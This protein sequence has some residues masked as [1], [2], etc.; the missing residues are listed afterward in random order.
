MAGFDMSKLE[1]W[2]RLAMDRATVLALTETEMVVAR[3]KNDIERLTIADRYHHEAK[4][5]FA[6]AERK[7]G[8]L[9]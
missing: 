5:L 2:Q 3:E 9:I 1:F 4:R 6:I 8:E 7:L